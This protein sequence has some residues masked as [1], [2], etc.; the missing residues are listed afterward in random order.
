ML[1]EDGRLRNDGSGRTNSWPSVDYIYIWKEL[2]IHTIPLYWCINIGI[3]FAY[4][5]PT[6]LQDT[7]IVRICVSIA[8]MQRLS[9]AAI[10]WY[11]STQHTLRTHH[12]GFPF[13]C[14]TCLSTFQFQIPFIRAFMI[15]WPSLRAGELIQHPKQTSMECWSCDL[16]SS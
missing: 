2:S 13:H 16:P 6:R 9:F 4:W 14:S 5:M 11:P 15:P 7:R 3:S 12:L 1:R 10:Q 8:F